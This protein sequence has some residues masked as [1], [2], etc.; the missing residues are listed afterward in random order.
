MK[1]N[2][3]KAKQTIT[4]LETVRTIDLATKN[5]L[6]KLYQTDIVAFARLLYEKTEITTMEVAACQF[7]DKDGNVVGDNLYDCSVDDILEE[8]G[9]E[10]QL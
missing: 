8:A 7:I 5:E 2:K 9:I 4:E 3:N 1:K 6:D 10:I